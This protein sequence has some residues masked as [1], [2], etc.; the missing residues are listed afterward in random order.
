MTPNSEN[1]QAE[2]LAEFIVSLSLE[3]IPIPVREKAK[4]C[5][6]DIL[7]ICVA[8]SRMPWSR[9][10]VAFIQ[11]MG[12]H[13]H[14]TIIGCGEKTSV[15]NAAL[16]NGTF[17]HSIELD[18]QHNESITHPA[19]V[20][21]TSA[22]A[23]GEYLQR[24]GKEI[25]T[26]IVAGYEVMIRAGAAIAPSL[27]V[28]RGFH[29]TA[30]T[31]TIGAAAVASKLL[32]LDRHKTMNALAIA[33]N[34]SS[35]LFE[36]LY[37]GGEFKR[38][39]PGMAASNGVRAGLLAEKGITGPRTIFEG[40]KGFYR[41]YASEYRADR[42]LEGLGETYELLRVAFKPYACCRLVH[43]SI[44]VAQEMMLKAKFSYD[45]IEEIVIHTCS[46]MSKFGIYH[47]KDTI[48]AQLSIPVGVALRIVHGN[49]NLDDYLAEKYLDK[50]V[51]EVADKVRLVTDGR[52]DPEYPTIIGAYGSIKLKNGGILNASVRYPKGEPENPLTTQELHD[53]FKN[54]T[55]KLLSEEKA[56]E[57][58][59]MSTQFEQV[60]DIRSLMDVI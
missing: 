37:S 55:N 9:A 1:T 19:S 22:L 3:A 45:D 57:V 28:D 25:L 41:A 2:V 16:A 8:G 47:P 32:Q 6:L 60:S 36:Y 23:L 29:P 26:A 44:D 12:G 53:K 49:N 34:Q 40:K 31:G 15:I 48:S 13:P 5:L 21:I 56:A 46:E 59:R 51:V 58:I 50:S 18:E 38:V 7:G 17:G 35:G 27:L 52:M 54:L 10:V 14:S 11:D 24:D 4:L 42:I 43:S 30:V 39:H 33:A 20:I